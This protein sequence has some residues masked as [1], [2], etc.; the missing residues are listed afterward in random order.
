VPELAEEKQA[1]K[2]VSFSRQTFATIPLP[3]LM[4]SNPSVLS[5]QRRVQYHAASR[6]AFR[7]FNLLTSPQLFDVLEAALPAH[8]ERLFPPTETLAMFMAQALKPD[9]SCQGIVDDMAV[10]RLL[11]DLPLCSTKTGGY[12]KARQR[13]PLKMVTEI[14]TTAGHL[15]SGPACSKWNWRGRRVC[16]VDGTT[17]TLAD[18]PANQAAYPQQNGQKP[19]MGFPICRIVGITCLASGALLNAAMG[20]FKGKGSGEQALLRTLLDTLEVSD[21]LLGDAFYATYFLLVELGMRGVDAVFEQH[22]ARQRTTDF[23]RGKSLGR[24]DHLIT[25]TKPKI[26]PEWMTPDQYE[27]APATLTIRELEVVGKVLVTTLLCAQAASKTDLKSLYKRRWHVELDIRNIKTT[28]GMETLSCK[29]PQ[30]GEKEMWVYLLAYNLIRLIMLQSALLADV[31]P[32]SLSIKHA[33]QLWLA[34]SEA[35]INADE[36]VC[37]TEFLL[38]VAERTV[39]N[40]PGRIEPRAVKRRP[41]PYPLLM[42]TRAQARQKIRMVGHPK[43]VK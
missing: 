40:R 1:G 8:R 37:A 9:R 42:Q 21:L 43:K 12:C 14:T 7:F 23:R 24:R 17:V 4:H 5:R 10:K 34:A 29:T 19:G 16:L 11:H 15:I 38:L 35:L 31:L 32:R 28:L 20:K 41:K 18:T 13:L 3:A 27:F 36:Q 2:M 39:G 6:D 33:L 26:R 25:L 22:G 30:M